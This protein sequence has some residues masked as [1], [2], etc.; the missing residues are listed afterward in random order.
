MSSTTRFTSVLLSV[1]MLGQGL[2]LL[3][4][5]KLVS[6]QYHRAVLFGVDLDYLQRVHG[7]RNV[8]CGVVGDAGVR[9]RVLCLSVVTI[10]LL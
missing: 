6:S 3:G 9:W 4:H 10:M 8:C 2:S 5:V 7:G 1:V